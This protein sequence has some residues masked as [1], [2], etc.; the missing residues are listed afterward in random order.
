MPTRL[1]RPV[2]PSARSLS[3]LVFLTIFCAHL[4]MRRPVLALTQRIAV[5]NIV[6]VSTTNSSRETSAEDT[7][8]AIP[9]PAHFRSTTLG[10]TH[11]QH[12]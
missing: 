6:K 2:R 8:L 9:H 5:S 7:Y 4:A 11:H 12:L 10:F 1:A 3:L